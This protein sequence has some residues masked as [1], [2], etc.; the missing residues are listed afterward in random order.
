MSSVRDLLQ[1]K[2]LDDL[3]E[4]QIKSAGGIMY[5]DAS[6]VSNAN[7]LIEISKAHRAVHA[8]TY[9]T[10]IPGSGSY[11]AATGVSINDEEI[12]H[13]PSAGESWVASAFSAINNGLAP[14]GVDLVLSDGT[15]SVTVAQ[16]V[17]APG[18][19]LVSIGQL[20]YYDNALYLALVPTSGTPGDII[21][22]AAVMKVI[23]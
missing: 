23:Q 20:V 21:I 10:P 16:S 8:P 17:A 9:G 4:A 14:V 3:T 22:N 7:D 19:S 11:K 12:I 15:N 18:R 2:T 13:Q 6:Q 5:V 1:T